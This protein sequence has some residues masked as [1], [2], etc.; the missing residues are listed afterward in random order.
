MNNNEHSSSN[1]HNTYNAETNSK[2]PK[3]AFPRG[4][5]AAIE[6]EN[7]KPLGLETGTLIP[8]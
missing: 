8:L 2:G 5:G 6:N 3:L 1:H 7:A 4:H